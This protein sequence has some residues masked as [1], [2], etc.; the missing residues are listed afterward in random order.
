MS[1]YLHDNRN[2]LAGGGTLVCYNEDQY[3]YRAED[4]VYL[5]LITN[6]TSAY[7]G[8]SVAHR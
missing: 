6:I 4:I 1:L 7:H 2:I 8:C 5:K 3:W